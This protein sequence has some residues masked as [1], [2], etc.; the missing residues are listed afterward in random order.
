[1]GYIEEVTEGNT[2]LSFKLERASCILKLAEWASPPWR[3]FSAFLNFSKAFSAESSAWSHA[4]ELYPPFDAVQ[5]AFKPEIYPHSITSKIV[6][7][8]WRSLTIKGRVLSLSLLERSG[9]SRLKCSGSPAMHP[10]K[11]RDSSVLSNLKNS[12]YTPSDRM[13]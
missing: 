11:N 9:N 3:N 2:Y 1:M 8:T 4:S 5:R 6:S 12:K 10:R 7:Q 13:Q